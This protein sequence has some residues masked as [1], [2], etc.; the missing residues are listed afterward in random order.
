MH[1]QALVLKGAG[2]FCIKYTDQYRCA[3]VDMTS[4]MS[5]N[6]TENNCNQISGTQYN[7]MP[8]RALWLVAAQVMDRLFFWL[9]LVISSLC[10]ILLFGRVTW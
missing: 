9:F 4:M 7:D 10:I 5:G 6:T 3:P 1:S 2:L 8:N